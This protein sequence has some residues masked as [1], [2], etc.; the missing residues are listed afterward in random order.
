M[1]FIIIL[2]VVLVGGGWLLGKGIGNALFGG[3]EK[4]NTYVDK[5]THV[6]NHYHDNRSVHLDG[7]EYKNLKK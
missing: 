4:K 5:T 3:S 2:F 7:K 6:H 1:D